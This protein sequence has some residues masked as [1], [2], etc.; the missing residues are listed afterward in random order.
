MYGGGHAQ[1]SKSVSTSYRQREAALLNVETRIQ[2]EIKQ[3]MPEFIILHWDRKV[4]KYEHHRET[5]DR[6]A[7]VDSFPHANQRHQFL[8]ALRIPHDTR[9]GMRDALLNNS[10]GNSS[11]LN[12][13]DVI[14]HYSVQYM[15]ASRII[16]TV[17]VWDEEGY[18]VV[19]LQT[20][21]WGAA[22]QTCTHWSPWNLECSYWF[23]L[24]ALGRPLHCKWHT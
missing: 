1:C 3:S 23:T 14:G 5:D 22:S 2:D 4:I 21:Y 18:P 16:S 9:V 19:G 11:C 24:W 12:L 13:S 7:I 15:M 20:S 8:A 10:V 17:S 6:L